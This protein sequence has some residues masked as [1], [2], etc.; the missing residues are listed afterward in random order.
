MGSMKKQSLQDWNEMKWMQ[1]Q[2]NNYIDLQKV[3]SLYFSLQVSMYKMYILLYFLIFSYT[4]IVSLFKLRVFIGRLSRNHE[5]KLI[6]R[7]FTTE[8]F[9]VVEKLL[10]PNFTVK[11]KPFP[12]SQTLLSCDTVR[13]KIRMQVSRSSWQK[14]WNPQFVSVMIPFTIVRAYVTQ[15][16]YRDAFVKW[17]STFRLDYSF[18]PP[19]WYRLRQLPLSWH[20]NCRQS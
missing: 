18:T 1:T 13:R 14:T 10:S 11:R 16:E 8:S 3:V 19:G 15:P 20:K 2:M 9:A 17:C 4:K 5:K 7:I 12:K 6:K